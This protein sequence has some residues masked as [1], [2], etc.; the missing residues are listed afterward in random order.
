MSTKAVGKNERE[1]LTNNYKFKDSK[2]INTNHFLFTIDCNLVFSYL[3]DTD[4]ER[5]VVLK[6]VRQCESMFSRFYLNEALE[7]V[8]FDLQL[9]DDIVIGS[10]F[11][12]CSTYW[13]IIYVS[14]KN[15][16]VN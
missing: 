11:R 1:D 6:A 13:K 14:F 15:A 9:R 3:S 7:D 4:E 16:V 2:Q 12:Y 8:R 5:E 10:P